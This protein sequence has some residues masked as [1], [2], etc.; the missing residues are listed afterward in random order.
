MAFPHL[1]RTLDRWQ[2]VV[3]REARVVDKVASL[4]GGDSGHEPM[5]GGF[6]RASLAMKTV[7]IADDV[8]SAPPA[9]RHE[10]RGIAGDPFVIKVA[11]AAAADGGDLATVTAAAQK[12]ANHAR[13]VGVA[14]S[15]DII[16]ASGTP[17]A[18]LISECHDGGWPVFL[19][20]LP[21]GIGRPDNYTPENIAFAVRAAAEL[22]AD[23]V[24]T[25]YPGDRDAFAEFVAS[26][27]VPV[28]V[29]GGAPRTDERPFPQDLRDAMDASVAGV[30]IGHN[31]WTHPQPAKMAQSL[32]GVVHEG[33]R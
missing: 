25:A 17:A 4:T 28:I 11:G 2:A 10:R 24:K 16:P 5:F 23:V 27:F 8:T 9:C 32:H 1:L 30:A 19:E 14:L 12:E 20:S 6:V 18:D 26:C 33:R 13:S 15:S 29:L 3:R 31:V 22:G 21:F 7:R